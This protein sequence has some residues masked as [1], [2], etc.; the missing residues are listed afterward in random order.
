MSH[1]N[2]GKIVEIM[3]NEI[4]IV[5]VVNGNIYHLRPSTPGINFYM[6]KVDDKVVIEITTE[7]VRVLS[8]IILSNDK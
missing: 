1:D 2:K 7:L 6:L 4:A 3:A 5:R 8:A